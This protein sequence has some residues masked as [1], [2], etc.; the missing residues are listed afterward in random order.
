MDP[1]WDRVSIMMTEGL[2]CDGVVEACCELAECNVWGKIVSGNTDYDI[3]YSD[4][5]RNE[6]NETHAFDFINWESYLYPAT[7]CGHES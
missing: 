4:T 6:H 5:Y 1:D 3:S 2:R 7:Q